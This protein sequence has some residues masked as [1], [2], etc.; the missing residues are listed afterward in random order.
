MKR[1]I[2]KG[3]PPDVV[4]QSGGCKLCA[5][6]GASAASREETHIEKSVDK[7]R[8][9]PNR[10]VIVAIDGPAGAGKSTMARALARRLGFFL[11]DT[12]ALYRAMALRLMRLG[13]VPDCAPIP[14]IVLETADLRIEPEPASMRVFLGNE[15]VT[16]AIR[17]ESVGSAA[18]KFSTRPEVR[19]ALLSLQRA[20]ARRGSMVAEGRD[21]GTVVFPDAHVKFFLTADLSARAQRRHREL[22]E[23]NIDSSL[24]EVRDSMMTRDRRDASR[25]ESPLVCPA[26][27]HVVDT[28]GLSPEQVLDIMMRHICEKVPSINANQDSVS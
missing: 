14:E 2:A 4:S 5:V 19:R 9:S 1:S 23:R 8:A 28:T 12:G 7:N 15:D 3:L 10:T 21:M 26:D 6:S 24:P 16:D 22:L 25:D 11:L 18:S 20:A 27:A 13:V 17:E